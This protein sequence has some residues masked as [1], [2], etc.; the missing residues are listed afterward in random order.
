VDVL[1]EKALRVR[2]ALVGDMQATRE[3]LKAFT[4][5]Y[6]SSTVI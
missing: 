1:L 6:V 5:E 3:I 4:R 2:N